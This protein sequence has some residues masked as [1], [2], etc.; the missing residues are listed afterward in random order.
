MR[1]SELLI[2]L[3]GGGALAFFILIWVS[4]GAHLVERGSRVFQLR[5]PL[6]GFIGCMAI[7]ANRWIIWS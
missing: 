3:A 7:L 1:A 6:L 2:W 5:W 4:I